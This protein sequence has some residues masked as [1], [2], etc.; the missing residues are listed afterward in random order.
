MSD[1]PDRTG[2]ARGWKA[3][4]LLISGYVLAYFA[5]V[6][7][8]PRSH[9]G[10]MGPWHSYR[11]ADHRLPDDAHIV[12]WPIHEL[13]RRLRHNTWWL[14]DEGVRDCLVLRAVMLQDSLRARTRDLLAAIGSTT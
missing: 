5:T 7:P 13:D 10:G 9:L 4:V 6:V 3:A 14:A 2:R 1:E 11:V 8:Y 12:F